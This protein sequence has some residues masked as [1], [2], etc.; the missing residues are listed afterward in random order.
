MVVFVSKEKPGNNLVSRLF[1]DDGLQEE[2]D[3]VLHNRPQPIEVDTVEDSRFLSP[4]AQPFLGN[5]PRYA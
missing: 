5:H 3:Q 4:P 2:P 1:V